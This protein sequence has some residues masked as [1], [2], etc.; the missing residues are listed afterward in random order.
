MKQKAALKQI[1]FQVTA[2]P[3][4]KVRAGETVLARFG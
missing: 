2:A 1:E 4:S 3:G